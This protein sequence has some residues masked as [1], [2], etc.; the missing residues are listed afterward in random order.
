MEKHLYINEITEDLIG[1]EIEGVYHLV[2]VKRQTTARKDFYLGNIRDKSGCINCQIPTY[3]SPEDRV[4]QT[5]EISGLVSMYKGKIYIEVRTISRTEQDL[6]ETKNIVI[7]GITHSTA[8]A[9]MQEL[10]K[11]VD[12]FPEETG[13]TELILKLYHQHR[14]NEMAA[15]PGNLSGFYYNGG[16]LHRLLFLIHLVD[17]LKETHFSVP[18]EVALTEQ[19][20]LDWALIRAAVFILSMADVGIICPMPDATENKR[21]GGLMYLADAINVCQDHENL[22]HCIK[23]HCLKAPPQIREAKIVEQIFLTG[24]LLSA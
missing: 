7:R 5:V 21:T 22:L 15:H 9:S 10:R 11:L 3:L 2:D 6:E 13:Y 19:K 16:A 14:V 1:E 20:E 12:D 18:E 4:N 17:T 8:V 23:V 24:D